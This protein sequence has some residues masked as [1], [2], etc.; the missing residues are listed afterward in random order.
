[1]G[2]IDFQ[3]QPAQAQMGLPV[4]EGQ[5]DVHPIAVEGDD[6]LGGQTRRGA[7]GDQEKPRL[8]EGGVVEDDDIDR[9]LRGVLIGGV[10]VATGAALPPTQAPEAEPLAADAH[11]GRAAAANDEGDVQRAQL[12][13][14]GGAGVAAVHDEDRFAARRQ[15]RR[16]EQEQRVLDQVLALADLV[17]RVTDEGDREDAVGDADPRH[18]DLRPSDGGLIDHDGD[19]AAGAS[20]SARRTSSGVISV[21][22]RVRLR[23]RR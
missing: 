19:P 13:E 14:E 6:V 12:R 1:M 20:P 17:V 7:G 23:S 21:P 8:L 9:F 2:R 22:S 11:E 5:L 15:A 18:E 4:A 16:D 10:H 3:P